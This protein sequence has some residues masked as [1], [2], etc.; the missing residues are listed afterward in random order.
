VK[1]GCQFSGRATLLELPHA[2]KNLIFNYQ[3]KHACSQSFRRMRKRAIAKLRNPELRK[4]DFY[5]YRYYRATEEYDRGHKDF[6]AVMNL[7][8][9]NSLLYVLLYK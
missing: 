4:I 3:N 6:E 5:N 9:H 1:Y 2:K 8:G 7:L